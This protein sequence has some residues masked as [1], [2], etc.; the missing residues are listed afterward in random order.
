MRVQWRQ[1]PSNIKSFS[2]NDH[3]FVRPKSVKEIGNI[4]RVVD[5][6]AS[7]TTLQSITEDKQCTS[8]RETQSTGRNVSKDRVSVLQKNGVIKHIRPSRL[9]P[10]YDFKS[11]TTTVIVTPDTFNYRQL[12]MAHL[13]EH[14]KILEIGCS[15][16]ICTALMMR[17]MMLCSFEK[18]ANTTLTA[19][20]TTEALSQR[21]RHGEIIAFDTGSDMVHET[22]HALQSEFEILSAHLPQ[23]VQQ[24]YPSLAS[25][26]KIDAFSDPKGAY[27]LA[28]K[29]NKHPNIVI[30]DI[31]GNRELEGVSR[32]IHW[33]QMT[34]TN[35]P[36]R[37][38]IVKSKELA[39]ELNANSN[40]IIENAQ[41]WL[42][43]YLQ[44][45]NNLNLPSNKAPVF[46]HPLRAPLVLSPKN[47]S[48]PI[49]RF[50]NY[51]VEGCKRYK[52][53]ETCPLDHE[54]CHWCQKAGHVARECPGS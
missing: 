36:P 25:V 16:G 53:G 32:M 19:S 51:H 14:D 43:N 40:V 22:K 37:T 45:K 20:E 10:I 11:D 35:F 26:H 33:V 49:C 34:F 44:S 52:N 50:H 46:A 6:S 1:Y 38:V 29:N 7:S 54:Y 8:E 13:R 39:Q 17:R 41:Q 47:E 15:T 24:M 21:K 3:V 42:N 48:I 18:E 5:A 28:S 9:V 2:E 4:G 30:I 12:A 31:G 27:A 23:H